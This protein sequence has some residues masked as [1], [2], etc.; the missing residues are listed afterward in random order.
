MS[1]DVR[2]GS[3]L[4]RGDRR[5]VAIADRITA[6]TTETLRDFPWS[7]R[8]QD[9][10]GRRWSTGGDAAHWSGLPLEVT[11]HTEAAGRALLAR[12][13]VG[14]LGRHLAGESVLDGDLYVVSG[15][16]AQARLEMGWVQAL[17]STLRNR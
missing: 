11:I 12:G 1:T 2:S 15:L 8:F 3:A 7:V 13:V 4:R 14:F 9:W 5:G 16:R 6:M 10:T 17:W